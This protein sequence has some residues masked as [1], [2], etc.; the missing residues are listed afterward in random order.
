MTWKSRT[1][2]SKIEIREEIKEPGLLIRIQD[3]VFPPGG[4]KKTKQF[5]VLTYL[6]S[7]QALPSP[8]VTDVYSG[9]QILLPLTLIRVPPDSGPLLG[10][11]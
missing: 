6:T 4:Q 2:K 10:N 1:T 9:T 7:V 5:E 8:T 11:I 3:P